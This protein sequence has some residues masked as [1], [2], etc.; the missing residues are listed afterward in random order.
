MFLYFLY[1]IKLMLI[2]NKLYKILKY[3]YNKIYDIFLP[4]KHKLLDI[5]DEYEIVND[6]LSHF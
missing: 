2:I 4:N 1:I 6:I 3:T 5:D